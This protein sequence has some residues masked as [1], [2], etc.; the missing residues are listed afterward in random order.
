MAKIEDEIA[1]AVAGE[2][3]AGEALPAHHGT[4]APGGGPGTSSW[5][6]GGPGTSQTGGLVADLNGGSG[7]SPELDYMIP[8]GAV[9]TEAP[10]DAEAREERDRKL[11]ETIAQAKLDHAAADRSF[12]E[13]CRGGRPESGHVPGLAQLQAKLERKDQ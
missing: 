5:N 7:T 4:F 8:G 10:E 2:L 6:Y 11:A 13:F 3:D 9:D 12:R 1:G